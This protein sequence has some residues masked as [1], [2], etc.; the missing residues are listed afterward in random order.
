L[1]S[2]GLSNCNIRGT[3]KIVH[4]ISQFD[5]PDHQLLATDA[6]Q[7]VGMWTDIGEAKITRSIFGRAKVRVIR[8]R[9]KKRR[10]WLLTA[11]AVM[12]VAAAAWQGWIALQKSELLAPP[13]SLNERIRVSAP[14][15]QPED[16]PATPT[17]VKNRQRTPA[18]I[19]LDG[20]TTRREPAPQRPPPK[21]IVTKAVTGQPLTASKPQTV[22][23]ATNNNASKNQTE[24]RQPLPVPIQPA[25][26]AV[27]APLA[28]Q[29]AA[30][31][32]AAIAP[33]AAPSIK[34]DT[35]TLSPAGVNQPPDPVNA[36]P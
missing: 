36:K 29:P 35:S 33:L 26:P 2:C 34:G 4:E 5:I 15:F 12:A 10:A 25:A 17:S 6:Q 14:I 9:D 18:Q 19:V 8:E 27:A 1:L 32:P 22:P 3:E 28:T 20:M 11:L 7:R 23:L 31:K 24:M 13:L 16:I 21:P 30:N